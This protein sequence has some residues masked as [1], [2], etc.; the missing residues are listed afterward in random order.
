MQGQLL[1]VEHDQTAKKDGFH[2]LYLSGHQ[3]PARAGKTSSCDRQPASPQLNHHLQNTFR[4][5]GFYN[6][7]KTSL[8]LQVPELGLLPPLQEQETPQNLF[9]SQ[10]SEPRTQPSEL[11]Y[12][13]RR[14][15]AN[16]QPK[17]GRGLWV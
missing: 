16:I 11:P 8:D 10:R 6:Y 2:F 14:L 17:A 12:P 4:P 13:W 3:T 5:A 9:P 7:P 1:R 15:A